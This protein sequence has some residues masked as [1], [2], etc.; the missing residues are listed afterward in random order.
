MLRVLLQYVIPIALPS[1]LYLAWLV[2]ENRRVARGGTGVLRKWQEGPWVW[3]FAIGVVLAVS[4]AIA[5][6]LV[7]GY[8]TEGR[9]VPPRLENGRIVPGHVEPA[10]AAR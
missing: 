4:V 7:G 10:P 6:S 5:L 1:V 8:G 3:L 9:Y 2:Y